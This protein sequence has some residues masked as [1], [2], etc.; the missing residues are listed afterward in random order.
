MAAKMKDIRKSQYYVCYLGWHECR[1]L[2]GRQ[3]V[4]PVLGGLVE[5]WRCNRNIP[6]TKITIQVSKKDVKIIQEAVN[7][8]GVRKSEKV[9]Y[10]PIPAKD[11]TFAC[12]GEAPDHDTVGVIYLG[13]NPQTNNAVHVH[14]YRCD[15]PETAAMLAQHLNQLADIPEHRQRLVRIERDLVEQGQILP[16]S[17]SLPASDNG[18]RRS[19][20][21]SGSTG[22][23]S[24]AKDISST[25]SNEKPPI[26]DIIH[27]ELR[28]KLKVRDGA[29][30]LLPPVDYDTIS[31]SRGDLHKKRK[32][33]QFNSFAP[34]GAFIRKV[35]ESSQSKENLATDVHH[36][37]P[38]PHDQYVSPDFKNSP[39]LRSSDDGYYSHDGGLSSSLTESPLHQSLPESRL[40]PGGADIS[41]R[42]RPHSEYPVRVNSP[43]HSSPR[44]SQLA[45][46]H[47]VRS[48]SFRTNQK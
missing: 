25:P 16:R 1:G 11:V 36:R 21:S 44:V 34:T 37:K 45:E 18:S 35:D 28:E 8:R 33:L 48:H 14:G 29:P 9:K 5:K 42:P 26:F 2:Y 31:R 43:Q 30:I 3:F 20:G 10:P 24:E 38:A 4:I 39:K 13:Y 46:N 22:S 12:Q 32:S 27:S 47:V 23:G 19:F 6:L 41:R 40:R 15:S 17:R 7:G